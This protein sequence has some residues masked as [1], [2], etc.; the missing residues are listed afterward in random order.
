MLFSFLLQ[1]R[2]L[3]SVF[4]YWWVSF[5]WFASVTEQQCGG[6]N[7]GGGARWPRQSAQIETPCLPQ[8]YALL[9][10]LFLLFFLFY[11]VEVA[12][13]NSRLAI[14][15]RMLAWIWNLCWTRYPIKLSSLPL[16]IFGIGLSLFTSFG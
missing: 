16:T 14:Y 1:L 3:L 15:F 9:F 12:G 8:T 7:M 4:H 11:L 13:S 6:G 2:V 5:S 10:L